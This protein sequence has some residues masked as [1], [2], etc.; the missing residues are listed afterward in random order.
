MLWHWMLLTLIGY[1]ALAK[2]GVYATF[3][4]QGIAVFWPPNAVVLVALLFNPVR[5]WL[6][7]LLMVVPAE[8]AADY[9]SFSIQ[10]AFLFALVNVVESALAAALMK[11][12][13]AQGAVAFLNSLKQVALFAVFAMLLASGFA[14]LLGALVYWYTAAGDIS[15]FALWRIWW[16]GDGLGLLLITPLLL[17]WLGSQAGFPKEN[18]PRLAMESL[19][20]FGLTLGL[21][22]LVFSN[23]YFLSNDFPL[24]PIILFPSV[25]WAAVRF[26]VRGASLMNLVI[27]MI[28]IYFTVHQA[29]PFARI[30]GAYATLQ[31]QE[32]LAALAL[33]SLGLAAMLQE[34]N[35]KNASLHLLGRAIDAVDDGVLITNA[36]SGRDYKILY[37]NKSFQRITG[38][39]VDKIIGANPRFLK[40]NLESGQAAYSKIRSALA[41]DESA[42]VLLQNRRADGALYWN[43]LTI[44]P[45]KDE[46]GKT[47]YY[48]GLHRDVSELVQSKAELIR[49]Q[50]TLKRVNAELEQK[51]VERTRALQDANDALTKLAT[52]D[53]LTGLSNRR[54]FFEVANNEVERARRYDRSMACLM[55]DIDHFKQINDRCGHAVG[56]RALIEFAQALNKGLRQEDIVARLG[57]EEFSVI[58]PEQALEEAVATAERLCQQIARL[59]VATGL[60]TP[61]E[62]EY[63]SFTVSIGVSVLRDDDASLEMLISRADNALYEAKKQGRNTVVSAK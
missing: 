46:T 39:A 11:R 8:I 1:F 2:L 41:R 16:F 50:Q 40:S 25:I 48:I 34:L 63:L 37:A 54:H 10:Q 42:K 56:D 27:A 6:W 19:A 61:Q 30:D 45:V 5:H 28:A 3:V 62:C 26:G 14:A 17:S 51:V 36:S 31:L 9:G 58:L 13:S 33:S 15:Y 4:D 18:F 22:I 29:G 38:Y 59:R 24:S 23:P 43:D 7:I 35:A 53:A 52:T 60:K 12:F 49:M 32:Y 47:A 57:G 55:L 21:S 20:L 44:S